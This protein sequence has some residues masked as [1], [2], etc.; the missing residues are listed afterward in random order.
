MKPLC[1]KI[2]N[3]RYDKFIQLPPEVF[4]S[5]FPRYSEINPFYTYRTV[6]LHTL[7]KKT[8]VRKDNN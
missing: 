1:P 2:K 6:E 4:A 7:V 8:I 5:I 3:T